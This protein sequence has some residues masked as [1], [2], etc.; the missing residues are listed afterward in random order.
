ML[1]ELH[2]DLINAGPLSKISVLGYLWTVE[3][4][5]VY[6]KLLL[7]DIFISVIVTA[8]S[9]LSNVA[10][11]NSCPFAKPFITNSG[12]H[13]HKLVRLPCPFFL[14]YV[15]W[16]SKPT[17][18]VDCSK[19][20]QSSLSNSAY[21]CPFCFHYSENFHLAYTLRPWYSEPISR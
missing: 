14:R 6:L 21:M 5:W 18:L 15:M 4:S 13:S 16:L 3:W 7:P 1:S 17:F 12:I 19:K 11:I 20:F 9:F 2:P 10:L 8:T